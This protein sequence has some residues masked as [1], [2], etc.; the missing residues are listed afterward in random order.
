[1][2][3]PLTGLWWSHLAFASGAL[4]LSLPSRLDRDSPI[5]ALVAIVVFMSALWAL[6]A[7]ETFL[8]LPDAFRERPGFAIAAGVALFAMPAVAGMITGAAVQPLDDDSG[9]SS[10]TLLIEAGI[11]TAA[12]V[13]GIVASKYGLLPDVPAN[14]LAT[15]AVVPVARLGVDAGQRLRGLVTGTQPTTPAVEYGARVGIACS[16]A[17]IALLTSMIV[18]HTGP[19]PTYSGSL[20]ASVPD[21]LA[22][23]FAPLSM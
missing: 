22:D 20:A 4:S 18:D 12:T 17:I 15:A 13:A 3:V 11:M 5:L 1:M 14:L 23:S 6:P 8:W 21:V 10:G 2:V 19:A 7:N 16:V 9:A